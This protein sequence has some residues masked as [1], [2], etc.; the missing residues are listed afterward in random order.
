MGLE[1]KPG[2]LELGEA[3][4]A[5][6]QGGRWSGHRLRLQDLIGPSEGRDLYLRSKETCGLVLGSIVAASRGEP[7]PFCWSLKERV[8]PDA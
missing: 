4:R 2:C 7:K 5:H 8:S 3:G 1:G 6:M